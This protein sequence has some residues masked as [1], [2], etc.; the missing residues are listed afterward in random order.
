MF[1]LFKTDDIGF[2][3]TTKIITNYNKL[4][5]NNDNNDH[6]DHQKKL[7][8]ELVTNFKYCP[9]H[10]TNK[11]IL[12]YLEIFNEKQLLIDLNNNFNNSNILDA[13]TCILNS[14]TS[15]NT[16][17]N[18]KNY[19]N[20]VKKLNVQSSNGFVFTADF[21]K[22]KDF[23]IIKVSRDNIDNSASNHEACVGFYGTNLLRKYIP[24][25]AYIYALFNCAEP[26]ITNNT[27]LLCSNKS[28]NISYIVYENIT[29]ISSSYLGNETIDFNSFLSYCNAQDFLMYYVQI[30]Y[31]L[32]TAQ[33]YCGFSHNDLH[34]KNILLRKVF[35]Y[36]EFFIKYEIPNKDTEYVKSNKYVAVLI[37]F[38]MSH[39]QIDDDN[40]IENLGNLPY[41]YEDEEIVIVLNKNGDNYTIKSN[42][43]KEYNINE[44][45]II[46]HISNYKLKVKIQKIKSFDKIGIYG[47]KCNYISD[48]YKLLL[49]SLLVL[50]RE[51][52]DCFTK[53]SPLIKYFNKDD[54]IY[55]ILDDQMKFYYNMP[56]I[57][58]NKKFKL[59]NWIIFLNKFIK[60]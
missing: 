35:K 6:Y 49:N 55:N 4:I 48:A 34:T 32:R 36:N 16:S 1:N 57:E 30:M 59:N 50:K 20:N 39:I 21:G 13:T 9:D 26:F 42:D 3:I 17:T 19:I 41:T 31:A 27:T 25:F 7:E 33:Y 46:T 2:N 44:K 10:I 51:N 5:N 45:D 54:N 29:S 52:Y 8:E 38:G 18:I 58:E 15:G 23:F 43:F 14:I 22:A 53:I 40:N 37:D 12:P 60:K 11:T 56:L 47:D 24:N 28:K